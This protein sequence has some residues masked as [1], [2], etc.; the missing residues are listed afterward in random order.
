MP[1]HD[2]IAP[3]EKQAAN[4]TAAAKR[5]REATAVEQKVAEGKLAEWEPSR[6]SICRRRGS[7]VCSRARASP[8][9][10]KHLVRYVGVFG[11]A[12]K[13]RAKLRVRARHPARLMADGVPDARGRVTSMVGT[14]RKRATYAEYVVF[15]ATAPVK[16]EYIAGEIRAM[17]GGTI[18]HGRLMANTSLLLGIALRARPCV[19]MPA[20]VRVRIRA[21]E[22]AT[23]PDLHVVCGAVERDPDDEL[24]VVNPTVIVEVLSESTE[25]GD[26]GDKFGAYRRLRSLREYVL[27]SQEER[28]IDV[29]TP[30]GR[31]WILD[32]Y[33]S[34]DRF[35]L[36]SIDVELAVDDVYTDG[37]G[38]ILPTA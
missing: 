26:R 7:R 12:S 9:A 25:D 20:D 24:A 13:H 28:R 16:H 15:A 21:A 6:K 33:R 32:E 2:D 23:Y 38:A 17:A 10:R 29:Y 1:P 36:A 37:I 27:V 35:T 5:A 11:P 31:R 8:P 18:E 34:G 4:R 22:R 19:V 30:E 3:F 14:A